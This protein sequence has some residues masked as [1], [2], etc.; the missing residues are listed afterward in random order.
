MSMTCSKNATPDNTNLRPITFVSKSLTSADGRYSNI[1][2]EV[3]GILHALKQ[4][5]YYCFIREVS[6][7][8]DHTPLVAIFKKDVA[9]LSQWNQCI[10]LQIHLYQVRIIYKPGSQLFIMDWLSRHNHIENKDEEICGMDMVDGIQRSTNIPECMSITQIQQMTTQNEHLQ[11]LRGYIITGWPEIK[12]QVQ[13]D[14][15]SYWSFR[16]DMAVI[17]GII[18]KDSHAIIPEVLKAQ[19]IDQFHI[20]HIGIEKQNL[21]HVIYLLG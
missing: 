18:M 20:H 16:D 8:T 12:D 9:T 14:I 3:L 17:D 4:F 2:R 7:I 21:W 13:H 19:A 1:E 6:I 15:W 11:W 10:L 5:H